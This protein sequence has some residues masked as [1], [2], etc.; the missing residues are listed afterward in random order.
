MAFFMGVSELPNI[1]KSLIENGRSEDEAAAV[2]FSAG[3]NQ[4]KTVCSTLSKIAEKAKEERDNSQPGIFIVGENAHS[5]FLYKSNGALQGEKVLLTCSE[6][7]M[8][9]AAMTVFDLGG[10]PVCMPMIKL[11]SNPSAKEAL[12]NLSDYNWLVAT[13]PSAA[14]CL[15]ALMKELKIDLRELP[16]IM[17]CGPGTAEEFIKNGIYPFIEPDENFGAEG[18]S[19]KAKM[20]LWDGDKILR[21]KSDLA[22]TGESLFKEVK[23]PIEITDCELYSNEAIQYDSAPDFDSVVFASASAVNAFVKNWGIEILKGKN[24]AVIGKPTL[25]ALESS[26]AEC[27]IILSSVATIEETIK[28]LALEN[29]KRIL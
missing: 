3:T 7:I 11:S 5:R 14:K 17:V 12:Q 18:L 26:K 9:K 24:A 13:S 25:N 21:L 1:V 4:E 2:V 6:A 28:A 27:N 15:M 23:Q 29:I 19:A 20:T 8:D 22:K 16:K 10:K